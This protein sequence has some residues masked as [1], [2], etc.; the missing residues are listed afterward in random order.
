MSIPNPGSDQAVKLGCTCPR[1]DNCRGKGIMIEG[2]VQFW[3]S[4]NCSLHGTRRTSTK[5]PLA[6]D[7]E[8]AQ[9]F[10]ETLPKDEEDWHEQKV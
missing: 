8:Q 3:V 6:E 1:I 7:S 4:E 10:V 2:V 9:T 5:N